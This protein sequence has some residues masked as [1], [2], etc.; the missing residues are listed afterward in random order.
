MADT[1][2][3]AILTV[4]KRESLARQLQALAGQT[5]RPD[6]IWIY[7]CGTHLDVSAIVR[8][9]DWADVNYFRAEHDLGYFGRFALATMASTALT[10]IIDD[11]MMPGRRWLEYALAKQA[12]HKAVISGQGCLLPVRSNDIRAGLYPALKGRAAKDTRVDFGCCSWLFRT[13]LAHHMWSIPPL[14]LRNAE[15]MHFGAACARLGIATVVPQ[16]TA[17]ETSA[18]IEPD[19]TFDEHASFRNEARY[20]LERNATLGYLRALGWRLR[21]DPANPKSKQP[22]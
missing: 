1:G 2:L 4:W 10:T 8:S 7:H 11:D 9:I 22:R 12:H 3:T 14:H 20:A 16:Q 19:W 21:S 15:D 17:N 6:A 5:R 18:D 13:E